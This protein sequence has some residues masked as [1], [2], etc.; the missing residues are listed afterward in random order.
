MYK[1]DVNQP[2]S[3]FDITDWTKVVNS[4]TGN[5]Y[6][7]LYFNSQP[8]QSL[9]KAATQTAANNSEIFYS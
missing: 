1:F 8:S 2:D 5:N 9:T 7:T 6:T 4:A 3:C